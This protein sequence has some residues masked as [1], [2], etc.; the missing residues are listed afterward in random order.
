MKRKP[1]KVSEPNKLRK[2]QRKVVNQQYP[3]IHRRRVNH[4]L[5]ANR[6]RAV[7]HHVLDK[8]LR[9]SEPTGR[10]NSATRSEPQICSKPTCLSEPGITSRIQKRKVNRNLRATHQKTVNQK[11]DVNHL[12]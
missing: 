7:N 6:Q 5:S 4:R 9:L 3:V 11:Q 1:I 10:N 2:T 8:P 12:C